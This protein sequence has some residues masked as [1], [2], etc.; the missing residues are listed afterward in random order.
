MSYHLVMA[1]EGGLLAS[2]RAVIPASE[3]VAFTDA[4]ALLQ[5]AQAI[6][7]RAEAEVA[8]LRDAARAEGLAEAAAAVDVLLADRIG[9]FAE[10]IDAHEAARRADIAAAALAALRAI[11]GTLED[12]RIVAGIVDQT[13]ARLPEAAPVR[14]FVA[15]ALA[16]SIARRLEARE[17]V[18]VQAD[19]GL[20]THDCVLRTA[21]G[22]VIA[23]LSV[24]LDALARRWG[25]A[26]GDGGGEDAA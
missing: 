6:R 21:A 14:L 19:A 22:Q 23:S 16:D 10:A 20:G 15:P 13:L 25:V 2:G 1:G 12:E 11:M 17:H 9:A 24:Q 3:R 7:A 18:T 8:S 26:C 4:V 5:A